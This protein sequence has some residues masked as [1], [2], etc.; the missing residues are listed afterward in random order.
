MRALWFCGSHL[1][2]RVKKAGVMHC[3][4][5][6]KILTVSESLFDIAAC[7]LL[8][9]TAFYGRMNVNALLSATLDRSRFGISIRV[10]EYSKSHT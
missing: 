2:G 4:H 6:A 5:A 8:G 1:G 3:K 10:V 7:R 9:I